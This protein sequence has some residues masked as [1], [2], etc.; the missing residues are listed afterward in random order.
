M[1]D[2]PQAKADTGDNRSLI[3]QLL[4]AD[5]DVLLG[6]LIGLGT[7]GISNLGRTALAVGLGMAIGFVIRRFLRTVSLRTRLIL[8]AVI[9][10]IA[11]PM[12]GAIAWQA[13]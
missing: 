8:L 5:V 13:I 9:V 10:V 6:A 4:T 7:V 11:L 1:S 12:I 3:R 2:P